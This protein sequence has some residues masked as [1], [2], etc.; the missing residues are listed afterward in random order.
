MFWVFLLVGLFGAFLSGLWF[1]SIKKS[2]TTRIAAGLSLAIFLVLFACGWFTPQGSLMVKKLWASGSQGNW[3]VIDN[4]GGET[5]RHWILS[6]AFAESS[7]QSDG[8]QFYDDADNLCYVSGDA[9]V[10][11][12][13]VPLED[14]LESYKEIYNIPADQSPCVWEKVEKIE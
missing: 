11:R 1:F 14:F 8:W 9:Y 6:D 5:L 10:M 12:I 2:Q 13:N 4:S 3:L 7:N